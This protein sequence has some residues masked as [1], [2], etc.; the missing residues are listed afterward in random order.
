ML[1]LFGNFYVQTYRR[2]RHQRHAR[3]PAPDTCNNYVISNGVHNGFANGL[4]GV[5]NGKVHGYVHERKADW[6][7][8]RN[9]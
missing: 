8:R 9:H 2:N 5:T 3:H 4:N 1:L 7:S 6:S